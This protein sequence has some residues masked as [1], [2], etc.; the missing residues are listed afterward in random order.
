MSRARWEGR[1]YL[2]AQPKDVGADICAAGAL[3]GRPPQ[4]TAFDNLLARPLTFSRPRVIR[5]ESGPA[6]AS[7]K[8]YRRPPGPRRPPAGP[9]ASLAGAH[10]ERTCST[11]PP[12][13]RR[14]WSAGRRRGRGA[15]QLTEA[16]PEGRVQLVSSRRRRGQAVPTWSPWRTISSPKRLTAGRWSA[17]ASGS[18][19]PQR[20]SHGP[21][22]AATERSSDIPLA[23]TDIFLT[24]HTLV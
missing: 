16:V 12:G 11:P 1:L 18:C 10:R 8:R 14:A 3:R 6:V 23:T 5:A 22:P 21:W 13:R 19:G 20:G 7:A 24:L 4:Q 2:P 15:T 9:Q 17:R